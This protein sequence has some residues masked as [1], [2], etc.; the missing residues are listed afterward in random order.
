MNI[1]TEALAESAPLVVVGMA[2]VFTG[3]FTLMVAATLMVRLSQPKNNNKTEKGIEAPPE[4]AVPSATGEADKG[5]IAAVAVALALSMQKAITAPSERVMGAVPSPGSP[6]G[7]TWT[8][9][10]RE[11]LMRSRGKVGHKWGR[12]SE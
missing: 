2:V 12:R 1:D 9:A 8:A 10:G 11:Q 6:T 7:S 4:V 5:T 3:L